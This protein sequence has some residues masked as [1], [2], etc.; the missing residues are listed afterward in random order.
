[1]LSNK[2]PAIRHTVTVLIRQGT[3]T[4]EVVEQTKT[5][6][7]DIAEQDYT[8]CADYSLIYTVCNYTFCSKQPQNNKILHLLPS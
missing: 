1:M 5:A 2:E 8:F 4:H 7:V 3:L 6:R